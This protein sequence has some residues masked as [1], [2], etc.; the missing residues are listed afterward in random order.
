M[1]EDARA[2]KILSD[3]RWR[4]EEAGGTADIPADDFNYAV[5]AGYLFEEPQLSHDDLVASLLCERRKASETNVTSAFLASLS[6]RKLYLRSALGSYSY[7][8]HFP[9]HSFKLDDIG[10]YIPMCETCGAPE[11]GDDWYDVNEHS[12]DRIIY[13]GGQFDDPEYARFD[14]REFN[15]LA[16]VKP[17]NDDNNILRMILAVADNMK[18][19]DRANQLEKALRGIFPANENERRRLIEALGY[20]GVLAPERRTGYLNEFTVDAE[21]TGEHKNDWAYPVI[22]WR[23]SDGVCGAAVARLF[24]DL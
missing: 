22:W 14:L 17:T 4:S 7:V 8:R 19:S 6:T 23:G 21:H 13:G 18:P 9:E 24:P 15:K 1:I 11:N 3:G 12:H 2:K 20:A 10:S 16:P 5:A